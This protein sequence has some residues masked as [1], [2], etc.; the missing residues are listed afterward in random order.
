MTR[1]SVRLLSSSFA[2][3]CAGLSLF[4]DRKRLKLL[5]S[6][7]SRPPWLGV[8]NSRLNIYACYSY[9]QFCVICI[10]LRPLEHRN[11][12]FPPSNAT[13]LPHSRPSKTRLN[14]VHTRFHSHQMTFRPLY[15]PISTQQETT[16][17]EVRNRADL[18]E[19][20]VP[21]FLPLS[22]LPRPSPSS[23]PTSPISLCTHPPPTHS[24]PPS[25]PLTIHR[26]FHQKSPPFLKFRSSSKQLHFIP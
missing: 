6:L 14:C 1:R 24:T 8:Q 12:C 20:C 21:R 23:P 13:P 18:R 9:I 2:S 26:N 4:G 15:T 25:N 3:L 10:R 22:F 16:A 17:S 5:F 11:L 7:F 19:T